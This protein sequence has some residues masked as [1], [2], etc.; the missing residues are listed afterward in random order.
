MTSVIIIAG[1]TFMGVTL[2]VLGL[3]MLMRNKPLNRIEDRLGLLTGK[4]NPAAKEI[5]LK[6]SVLAHPLDDSPGIFERFI[7][8]FGDAKQDLRASRHIADGIEV[9]AD[10]HRHD[11]GRRGIGALPFAL[12]HY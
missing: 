11:V 10:F 7:Q 12:F 6:E 4:I 8:Q 9:V 5:S 3:A 1:I 2:I